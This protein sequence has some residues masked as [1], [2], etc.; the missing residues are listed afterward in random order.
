MELLQKYILRLGFDHSLLVDSAK[1]KH[2]EEYVE[3]VGACFWIL[4]GMVLVPEEIGLNSPVLS[5]MDDKFLNE[6]VIGKEPSESVVS[7]TIEG[8]EIERS[9]LV[10]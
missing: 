10:V 7:Q 1:E 6:V 4:L 5:E 9:L 8:G 2:L 3:H